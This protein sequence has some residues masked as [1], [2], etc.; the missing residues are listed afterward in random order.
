MTARAR[1]S[2]HVAM[3]EVDD[4]SVQQDRSAVD[5][6]RFWV[7]FEPVLETK[8]PRILMGSPQATGLW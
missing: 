6:G 2:N 3:L 5:R 4:Q 8:T 7:K 1:W